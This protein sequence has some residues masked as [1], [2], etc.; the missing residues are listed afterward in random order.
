MIHYLIDGTIET[1]SIEESVDQKIF[2]EIIWKTI[3]RFAQ[4]CQF[5]NQFRKR[6]FNSVDCESKY[7][8]ETVII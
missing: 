5:T 8:G 7:M 6:L 3:I 2:I 4:K 1:S